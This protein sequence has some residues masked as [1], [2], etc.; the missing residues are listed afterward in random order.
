MLVVSDL[1]NNV[2]RAFYLLEKW[3]LVSFSSPFSISTNIK[4]GTYPKFQTILAY[5]W[6]SH[7]S[8]LI[9]TTFLGFYKLLAEGSKLEDKVLNIWKIGF[10]LLHIYFA[11]FYH[12]QA[13]GIA[14][15]FNQLNNFERRYQ[16]ITYNTATSL[17][18]PLDYL[19]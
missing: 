16:G 3:N 12:Q 18:L 11:W 2:K 13:S 19:I 4:R 7:I 14:E 5:Q 1:Q 15:F 10:F 6:K 9:V 17:Q 8:I